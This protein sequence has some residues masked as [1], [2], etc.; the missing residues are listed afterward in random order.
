MFKIS[1]FFAALRGTILVNLIP[2]D[3]CFR[4]CR[5]SVSL[6]ETSG[7]L[8]LLYSLDPLTCFDAQ[9]IQSLP[10]RRGR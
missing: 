9:Q 1:A 7:T 10:E 6:A 8:I 5:A 4:E 2:Y 3:H